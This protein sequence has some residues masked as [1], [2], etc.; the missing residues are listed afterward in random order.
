MRGTLI[1]CVGLLVCGASVAQAV[2]SAV[3]QAERAR[4]AIVEKVAASVVAQAEL[5]ALAE[6]LNHWTRSQVREEDG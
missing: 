1:T 4:V 2:D 5:T 6:V 3:L